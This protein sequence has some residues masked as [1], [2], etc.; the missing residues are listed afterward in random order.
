[1]AGSKTETAIRYPESADQK[2]R[3]RNVTQDRKW[4][5]RMQER[6]RTGG[7][8]SSNATAWPV[9]Q[10]LETTMDDQGRPVPDPVTFSDGTKARRT[11]VQPDGQDMVAA[12]NEI[13]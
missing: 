11:G 9:E 12:V 13:P 7:E 1:M 6:A 10:L 8:R 4:A 3:L 2:R 5:S